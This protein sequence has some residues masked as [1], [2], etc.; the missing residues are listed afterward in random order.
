MKATT[1]RENYDLEDMS[2]D[3]I[4]GMLKTHNLRWSRGI[5][6]MVTNLSQL[7]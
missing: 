3:E 7:P 5:R 4:Y 6:D 2:L 1:V